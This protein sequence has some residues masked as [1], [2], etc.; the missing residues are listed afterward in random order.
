MN[1]CLENGCGEDT[2][3]TGMFSDR[4]KVLKCVLTVAEELTTALI[5]AKELLKCVVS[6]VQGLWC[7]LIGVQ[8]LKIE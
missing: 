8:R 3:Y 2:Y 4:V 6:G 7:T 1:V 5:S